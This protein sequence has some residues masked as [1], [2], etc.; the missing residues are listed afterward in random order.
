MYPP[1]ACRTVSLTT[2]A[3]EEVNVETCF[4]FSALSVKRYRASGFSLNG[5]NG[6]RKGGEGRGKERD[7]RMDDSIQKLKRGWMFKLVLFH[8]R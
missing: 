3:P 6:R 8:N 5:R 4:L 7:G 1:P 2:S